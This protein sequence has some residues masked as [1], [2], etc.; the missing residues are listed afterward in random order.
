MSLVDKKFRTGDR[1]NLIFSIGAGSEDIKSTKKSAYN[2]HI[3]A[4]VWAFVRS[5]V[6]MPELPYKTL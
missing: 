1:C 4:K 5:V 6:I 3:V 2:D